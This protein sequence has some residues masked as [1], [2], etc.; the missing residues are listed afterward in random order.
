MYTHSA[1][2]IRRYKKRNRKKTLSS[3]SKP[4]EIENKAL[5][6]DDLVE[7]EKAKELLLSIKEKNKISLDELFSL[8]KEQLFLPAAIF[9]K[10]LTVL[11]SVVKFL[12]EEKN[13]SLHKISGIIGRDERNIWHI[14]NK[15]KKRYSK[16]FIIKN[17][18]FWIPVSIF[19]DNKLS[20]QESV[21]VYLKE[22]FSLDY[23]QIALLL[24]RSYSTIWTVHNR[25]SKKNAK[26]K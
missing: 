1:M 23:H 14:Y 10:K 2:K 6:H 21:V 9:N 18:K 5:T 16:K 13:F 20:A 17:V 24:K 25:A 26:T 19:S 12:K 15:A 7:F 4:H 8:V 22:K 3:I 11:E